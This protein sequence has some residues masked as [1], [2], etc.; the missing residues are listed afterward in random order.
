MLENLPGV[1]KGLYA[2]AQRG[3]DREWENKTHRETETD[4]AREQERKQ[5]CDY[6]DH[7]RSTHSRSGRYLKHS[8]LRHQQHP[9]RSLA[10]S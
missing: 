4:P 3:T 2:C 6:P 10:G 1:P 9:F 8:S 5:E 7:T